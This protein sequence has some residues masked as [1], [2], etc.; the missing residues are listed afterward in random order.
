MI[1]IK[2]RKKFLLPI[3]WWF[4]EKWQAYHMGMPTRMDMIQMKK[5]TMI[6]LED[7]K[8]LGYDDQA[9]NTEGKLVILN[10]LINE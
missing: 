5:K 6:Q 2:F 1:Y 4:R 7:E 10:W 3:K 8:R 9:K